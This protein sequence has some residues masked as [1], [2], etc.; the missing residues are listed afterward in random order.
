MDV[1]I[2]DHGIVRYLERVEGLDLDIIRAEILA[3]AGPAAAA[4]AKILRKVGNT[5]I[6]ENGA[7]VTVLPD[8]RQRLPR[9]PRK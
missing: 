3:I 5:Y 2:S 6:I 7:I 9:R 8:D 4:G 1:R